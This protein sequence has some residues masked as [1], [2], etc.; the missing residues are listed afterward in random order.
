MSKAPSSYFSAQQS[1]NARLR[2]QQVHRENSS[3]F[4]HCL[5]TAQ[6]TGWGEFNLADAITFDAPFIKRPSFTSG[7]SLLDDDEAAKLRDT[8][9]PRVSAVVKSWDV[10]PKG[11]YLGAWVLVTVEDRSALVEPTVFDPDPNYTI[12]HDFV[13]LGVAIKMLPTFKPGDEA[14]R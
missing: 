11:L 12:V 7:A 5:A 4:A 13:F 2:E 10:N 6:T 3:R 14:D 8:R 9:Y 1:I